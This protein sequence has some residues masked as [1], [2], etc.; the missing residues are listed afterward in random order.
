MALIKINKRGCLERKTFRT[1]PYI[2]VII[3]HCF[4]DGR[5]KM[6]KEPFQ[7]EFE[8]GSLLIC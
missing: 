3:H 7:K 8:D 6:P 4:L 2:I 1:L 5:K